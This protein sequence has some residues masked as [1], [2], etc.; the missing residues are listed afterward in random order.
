MDVP[1]WVVVEKVERRNYDPTE[2]FAECDRCGSALFARCYTVESDSGER[3]TLGSECVKVV[4]GATIA[5][6]ETEEAAYLVS[7][8]QFEE[9]ERETVRR[10]EW[11]RLHEDEV[12]HIEMRTAHEDAVNSKL[13]EEAADG[14]YPH[15]SDFWFSILEGYRRYGSLTEG[16]LSIVRRDMTLDLA[17]PLPQVGDKVEM[18]GNV[19][20]IRADVVD[21]GGGET[22]VAKLDVLQNNLLVMLTVS[23]G[24]KLWKDLGLEVRKNRF[25]QVEGI[26]GPDCVPRLLGRVKWSD[27]AGGRFS[28]S[29]AKL[30][31]S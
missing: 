22:V 25:G 15:Y 18:C 27:P 11:F 16:Q 14:D 4:T 8:R 13:A 9:D 28:V 6:L 29:R 31:A 17:A 24:S 23:E 12:S 30:L 2:P 3:L 19:S 5:K 21:F 1:K 26:A 20:R 10:V 7:C